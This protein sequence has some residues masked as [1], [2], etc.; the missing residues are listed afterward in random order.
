MSGRQGGQC[1]C[2]QGISNGWSWQ[3]ASIRARERGTVS[4]SRRPL[5]HHWAS[6]GPTASASSAASSGIW[7]ALRRTWAECLAHGIPFDPDTLAQLRGAGSVGLA[8]AE[9][10]SAITPTEATLES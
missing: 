8:D 6:V 2:G 9:I 3:I 10:E 4:G 1:S 7:V 5:V